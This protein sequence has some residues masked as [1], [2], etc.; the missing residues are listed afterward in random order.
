MNSIIL[1]LSTRLLCPILSLLAIYALYR[2]HNEPGGGFIGGLILSASLIFKIL[3]FGPHEIHE[4]LWCTPRQLIISGLSAALIAG[5]MPL[6]V[7]KDFLQSLWLPTFELP[8][9]GSMHIGTP[10]LF[11]IGVFMI[12]IGFVLTVI[13]ELQEAE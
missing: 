12:V 6:A 2:G 7:G 3:A 11:D 1:K 4:R 8:L 13:L 10:L 9:L 5:L